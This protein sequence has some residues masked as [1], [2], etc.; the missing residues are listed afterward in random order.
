MPPVRGFDRRSSEL[1]SR[2]GFLPSQVSKSL[3][4]FLGIFFS[5][6][7]AHPAPDHFINRAVIDG[8]FLVPPDAVQELYQ[9]PGKDVCGIAD[10]LALCLC[11]C[12]LLRL[13]VLPEFFQ[14]HGLSSQYCPGQWPRA[15]L[16]TISVSSIPPDFSLIRSRSLSLSCL[17][18][19][20]RRPARELTVSSSFAP[21]HHAHGQVFERH[22]RFCDQRLAGRFQGFGHTDSVH[23]HIVGLGAGCRRG[24][25]L[26]III[27]PASVCPGLSSA[28]SN[29]GSLR[30]A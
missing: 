30:P 20:D 9:L 10:Q 24:D 28:Q 6:S 8:L 22:R 13:F 23:N 15:D 3:H 18:R 17:F 11:A 27:V 29:S 21:H 1:R 4:H 19:R 26:Q 2:P 25:F 5:A 14:S 16:P 7:P 12:F